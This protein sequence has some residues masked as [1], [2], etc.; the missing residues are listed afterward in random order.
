M[1]GFIFRV[2]GL[3]GLGWGLIIGIFGKFSGVVDGVGLE[4]IF[5]ESL[6]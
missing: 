1:V 4:V 6:G 5:W 2:S 3:V